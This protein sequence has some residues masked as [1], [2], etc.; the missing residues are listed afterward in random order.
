MPAPQIQKSLRRI[1]YAVQLPSISR[2]CS[3]VVWARGGRSQGVAPPQPRVATVHFTDL[4]QEASGERNH[5]S[6]LRCL[7]RY[8]VGMLVAVTWTQPALHGNSKLA[9]RPSAHHRLAW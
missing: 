1:V 9:G 8:V 4:S 7:S 5:P 2:H 6:E 3:L